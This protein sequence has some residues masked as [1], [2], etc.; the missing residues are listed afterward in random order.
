MSRITAFPTEITTYPRSVH[1]NGR[2]ASIYY[3][4]SVVSDEH[5]I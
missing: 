5:Y 4:F 3:F 2:R 1:D